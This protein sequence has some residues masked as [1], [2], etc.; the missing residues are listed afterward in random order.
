MT[1]PIGYYVP[2]DIGSG[3]VIEELEQEWG[4]FFTEL[5]TDEMLWILAQIARGIWI[6]NVEDIRIRE[7]VAIGVRKVQEQVPVDLRLGLIE[8]LCDQIKHRA[9]R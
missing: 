1:K 6:D 4:S 5:K 3:N 7:G 8:A 2:Y 9:K